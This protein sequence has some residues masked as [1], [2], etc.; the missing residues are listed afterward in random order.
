MALPK[1]GRP[2]LF[3]SVEELEKKIQ[4]YFDSCFEE[5]WF[6]EDERDEKG[7][8]VY[9]PDTKTINKIHKKKIIQI[10]PIT[11]T[12]LAWAL[13]CSRETLVNY[14]E[15]EE[16]FR[17]IK[18]AR[19]FVEKC[20]EMQMLNGKANTVASIFTLKNNWNWIEKQEVEHSG[21]INNPYA[22]L[23][24][25]QIRQK[26]ID[27]GRQEEGKNRPHLSDGGNTELPKDGESSQGSGNIPEGSGEK[28]GEERSDTTTEGALENNG[29][30]DI[31]HDTEDNQ[32]S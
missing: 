11:I 10:E 17:P 25:E 8:P 22:N 21:E 6:D 9:N 2:L 26:L 16:F 20:I 4:A 18:R 7:N 5:K 13:D 19:D 23:T 31:I 29:N 28:Q 14:A 30:N 24:D 32:Q 12:G 27:R 3:Q 15:K 1:V